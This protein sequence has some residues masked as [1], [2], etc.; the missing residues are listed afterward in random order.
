M[1]K[2]DLTPEQKDQIVAERLGIHPDYLIFV[3]N[4]IQIDNEKFVQA[5]FEFL[6]NADNRFITRKQK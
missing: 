3:G 6:G 4:R 1:N 2:N 5:G